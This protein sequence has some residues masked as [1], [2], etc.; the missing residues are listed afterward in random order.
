MPHSTGRLAFVALAITAVVGGLLT[1]A[2]A[3]APKAVR[4]GIWGGR[5]R[6]RPRGESGSFSD[7][8]AGGD[9]SRFHLTTTTSTNWTTSNG[10]L[11]TTEELHVAAIAYRTA[12]PTEVYAAF[13]GGTTGSTEGDGTLSVSGV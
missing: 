7:L 8:L 6:Q 10:G 13:G 1:P 3:A 5:V 2:W 12:V 11:P 4:L 9:D